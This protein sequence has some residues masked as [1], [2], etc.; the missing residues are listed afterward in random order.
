VEAKQTGAEDPD[1]VFAKRLERLRAAATAVHGQ[2][3]AEQQ[4]NMINIG[5]PQYDSPPPLA[6]TLFGAGSDD[7]AGS[8]GSG[9]G[10]PQV[11]APADCVLAAARSQKRHQPICSMR[12]GHAGSHTT[13]ARLRLPPI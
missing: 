2:E 3:P 13:H 11:P 4:N 8:D 1:A 5:R 9:F 6:K 10:W 7:G 12:R